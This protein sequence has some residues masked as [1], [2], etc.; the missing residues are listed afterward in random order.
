MNQRLNTRTYRPDPQPDHR[1]PARHHRPGRTSPPGVA[2]AQRQPGQTALCEY[3]DNVRETSP[4]LLD[5]F[6]ACPC[7]NRR[8]QVPNSAWKVS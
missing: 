3:N 7:W 1:R 5:K 4:G 8:W 6:R 2:G